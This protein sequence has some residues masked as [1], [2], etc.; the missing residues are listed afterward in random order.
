MAT[1]LQAQQQKKG[2]ARIK[3][4]VNKPGHAIS[5]VLFGVFFED[6]NLSAD[7][8]L[9]PELVRNRSFEDA[10]SLENWK[11]MSVDGK[12]TASVRLADV[13]AQPPLPPLNPFN[14]K[15][16]LIKANG[17]F[18]LEN[19]G[20]WGM[21][22]VQGNSYSFKMAASAV[23]TFSG[24]VKVRLIGTNGSE[25]ASALIPGIENGWKYYS[26][27]LTAAIG[28]PKAR[29]EISCEGN[30]SL[31]LDMVSLLPSQSWKN[32][33][34][35]TDLAEAL[36]ALQPRFL[37]FPGGCWVEG[38][39][40]A[41]MN[42]WKNTIGDI[43]TRTPLWNIWGYNATHGLGYH[44]YLQ[45][46]EDLGAE[47][48]FC[49]NAGI[50]HREVVPLDQMGQWIQD[51]LDAIEYA[52]GP[53]T[54]VWG[55]QRARNGHPQPFN[56]KYLEIG[57][58]NGQ[59]PYAERWELMAKAVH[60]RYPDVILIANEW[61][62]G[63]PKEPNPEYIDE[64]YYNN[65]DWFIWN[66]NKYDSYDRKGPKIFIG[67]YAVT[68]NTG[69]GNLRGAI[70]EAAWMIGM[71]RNSDIVMMGSYAPLFCNSNHKAWPVNLI[72]FDS[73]RWFGLPSYYVQK[74]F[75]TNQGTIALPVNIEKAPEIAAP[76][77]SG[78]IGLGTW[79]NAADF[80]DLRVV[81]PEGKVLYSSENIQDMDGWNLTGPG[82][83]SV[84]D[85][86]ITQS[87]SAPFVT[88]F[89]GDTNWTDYT[90]T[91]KARKISGENGFQI[92]F[93]NRGKRERLR[94]DLG[95]FNNSVHYMEIG[96][97]T[98]SQD[99]TID[100]G[101]WYDVRIEIRGSSVKGY[102]DGKLVQELADNTAN[103]KSIC[104]SAAL[105]EKSGDIILK[106]VNTAAYAVKTNIELEGAVSL[107][108]D[109]SATVL[110]SASPLDENTLEQP[111][112]VSPK[113]TVQ[114]L[115]GT[116]LNHLF[117]GNSL[118][119]IRIKKPAEKN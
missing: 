87:A 76:Y 58:E 23:N 83:W 88:A 92:Y 90:I 14:R 44:E 18:R 56:L 27:N 71:E 40:F 61:F 50:S 66:A 60:D 16:L 107:P 3:I 9:Y 103:V 69:N 46:A 21:N 35:R 98:A 10:E 38:D 94:W 49:V 52:N 99:G 106:F 15:Y 31:C 53:V 119:V 7:G 32:H 93:H 63:H 114:K 79:N 59:A 4:E 1:V 97:T 57:N 84:K 6:I 91:L 96:M 43:A 74:L 39:D 68:S 47:P 37:R 80:K 102:L 12:S 64:H 86:I 30:G 78:Y 8:G 115:S 51:A 25:L 65:P 2:E 24:S 105:D 95:G 26:L 20:Y 77:A 5:P 45:L 116:S 36:D 67:E 89:V 72:N 11:F 111:E 109:Y 117:P 28:D 17:S 42:H 81:S 85:G 101:R 82:S 73:Y 22:I 112:K 48:L 110:T 13:Q 62:G 100:A 70:G 29:L 118:T 34:M 41:H 75:S 33:G 104:A 108:K 113:T 19:E 54:S 55:G